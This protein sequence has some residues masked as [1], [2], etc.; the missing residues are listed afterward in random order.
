M[1]FRKEKGVRTI[2]KR[3]GKKVS[4][5]KTMNKSNYDKVRFVGVQLC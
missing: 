3:E 5:K 2:Y 4:M 1:S